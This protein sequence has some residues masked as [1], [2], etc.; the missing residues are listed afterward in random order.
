MSTKQLILS[1][2]FTITTSLVLSQNVKLKGDYVLL[3]NTKIMKYDK[4]KV[5]RETAFIDLGTNE[6]VLVA[7]Y[8]NGGNSSTNVDDYY[9]IIFVKQNKSMEYL[10]TRWNKALIKWLL[11]EKVLTADGKVNE[12]RLDAF[13]EEYDQNVTET[14]NLKMNRLEE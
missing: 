8:L 3:E 2:F 14:R 4:R 6:E 10:A 13:I 11:K 1:M 5:G 9:R 12:S 7:Q